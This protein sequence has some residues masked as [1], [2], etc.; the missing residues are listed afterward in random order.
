MKQTRN[1]SEKQSVVPSGDHAPANV[2]ACLMLTGLDC[3]HAPA[4]VLRRNEAPGGAE[5]R[6]ACPDFP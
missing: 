3:C 1:I 6:D 2:F 5:V 4:I